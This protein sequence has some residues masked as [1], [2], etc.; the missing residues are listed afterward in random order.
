MTQVEL[1]K[2]LIA[3]KKWRYGEEG[4]ERASLI[5]AKLRGADLR[6][7]N[8]RAADLTQSK[9]SGADLSGADLR[10][11]DLRWA[12]LSGAGLSKAD[13]RGVNLK[14]AILSKADLSG[15]NLDYSCL[16]L[17]CGSLTAHFDDKQLKQI[18]YHLLRAGLQ[19]KNASKETKKELSKLVDFAN[20]FHRVEDYGKIEPYTEGGREMTQEELNEVLDVHEKWLMSKE[21]YLR[22]RL[23][24]AI[25]KLKAREQSVVIG[26]E[27][28]AVV[29]DEDIDE[30]FG[31]CNPDGEAE[32]PD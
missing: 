21:E 19:S 24:R 13:L 6:G 25:K 1:N 17:W 30:V 11:A 10:E 26:A 32:N 2:V 8:L 31:I 15:A 3:H 5:G 27:R 12:D 14:G 22:E 4:G 16:P 28:K 18:A 9:L 20:G 23:G 29:T 7:V